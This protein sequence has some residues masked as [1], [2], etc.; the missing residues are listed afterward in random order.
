[1]NRREENALLKLSEYLL[2]DKTGC[3]KSIL[4]QS[5]SGEWFAAARCGSYGFNNRFTGAPVNGS[6]VH[7]EVILQQTALLNILA[8][9]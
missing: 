1:L 4:R 5:V 6:S 8:G 9:S 2:Y 3:I 7:L